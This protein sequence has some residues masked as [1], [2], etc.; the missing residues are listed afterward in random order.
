M[1]S[2]VFIP[3]E[4]FKREWTAKATLAVFLAASGAQV[5][6]GHK[7]HVKRMAIMNG[8]RGDIYLNNHSQSKNDAEN[9][10]SLINIGIKIIGYEDEG[11]LDF[12]N[13]KEQLTER[14]SLSGYSNFHSWL[15]WGQNE[16]SVLSKENPHLKIFRNIGTPRS[17]LWGEFGAQLWANEVKE[18]IVPKYGKYLLMTTS[19]QARASTKFISSIKK[20]NDIYGDGGIVSKNVEKSMEKELKLEKIKLQNFKILISEILLN[21]DFNVVLRP[22]Y[23]KHNYI[24]NQLRRLNSNRIFIDERLDAAPLIIGSSGLFHM[25]S[26]VAI[27]SSLLGRTNFFITPFL[28]KA[29]RYQSP[30]EESRLSALCS[31]QIEKI[32]NLVNLIESNQKNNFDLSFYIDVPKDISFYSEFVK[33]ITLVNPTIFSMRSKKLLNLSLMEQLPYNLA[34]KIKQGNLYKYDK[35]KRPQMSNRKMKDLVFMILKAFGLNSDLVKI[36]KLDQSTFS[37]ISR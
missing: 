21:S 1:T 8:K 4:Y 2:L 24:E 33:L 26:T 9:L 14:N 5:V 3:V 29:D 17:A 28:D 27:E 15:S 23:D 19:F 10:S 36:S 25:G 37:L 34:I 7:W 6:F 32:D 31:H 16:T 20:V 13:L 11:A 18:H 12:I 22:Y 30:L 35:L